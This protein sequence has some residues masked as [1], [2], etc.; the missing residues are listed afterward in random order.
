[1][2]NQDVVDLLKAGFEGVNI[3]SQMNDNPQRQEQPVTQEQPAA[4]TEAPAEQP[5][6]P[7]AEATQVTLVDFVKQF[8]FESEDALKG[9]VEKAKNY[10]TLQTSYNDLENKSKESP[11]KTEFGKIA[12]ELHAKGV[13]PETIAK[14]HGL[15]I[16]E[17]NSFD[18]L[19]LKM[20]V[21][22]PTLAAETIEAALKEKY[23][24]TDELLTD[25]AKAQREVDL[26][27]DAASAAE[28]LDKHIYRTF[29]PET[30]VDPQVVQK[31]QAR[32]NFWNNE[33]TKFQPLSL[34]KENTIKFHGANGVTEEK[35]P[36]AYTPSP[37]IVSQVTEQFKQMVASPSYAGYYTADQIGIQNAQATLNNMYWAAAGEDIVNNLMKHVATI[38]SKIHQKY[39]EKL[40]SPVNRNANVDVATTANTLGDK[41]TQAAADYLRRM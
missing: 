19:K 28:F 1:M 15:K 14:F 18:K 41:V 6:Q 8:G 10:D 9:A 35:I 32:V 2:E 16:D 31:E 25:G 29:N 34:S 26:V 13:K 21:E 38:E 20:Q 22:Y 24:T 3:Q 27:R 7:A 23:D 33:A 40:G 11:F 5:A 37:E 36:F 12:D 4:Q 39:A 30:T 17:L